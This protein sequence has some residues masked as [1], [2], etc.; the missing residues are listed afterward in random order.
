MKRNLPTKL[1]D[2]L[3]QWFSNCWSC[4][5]WVNI[6]SPFYKLDFGVRQGSVLSPALFTIYLDGLVCYRLNGLHMFVILYADDIL[7]IAQSVNELQKLL[8]ACEAELRWFDM[9]INFKKTCCI[10]VGSRYNAEFRDITTAEG[11]ALP[12]VDEVK[13]LGIVIL[14]SRFFK[15]SFDQAKRAL[16]RSL[17]AIFGR[18]GR[19]VSEEVLLQLVNSKCLPIPLHDTEA[20]P[21]NKSDNNS[22]DF[23]TNRFLMKLCKTINRDIIATCRLYFNIPLPSA[24]IKT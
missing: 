12:W 13:Y 4:V 11:H 10:R 3:M 1:L 24:L 20:C 22:F 2:I 21:L 16:Y 23:I 17:N 5:K 8:A 15:C 18:V 9:N 19:L 6:F 14:R 7:L